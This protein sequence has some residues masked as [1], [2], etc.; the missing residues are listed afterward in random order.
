ME[1]RGSDQ[2]TPEQALGKPGW[3]WAVGGFG[4]VIVEI[5]EG[6]ECHQIDPRT[7]ER[8]GL[9]SDDGWHPEAHLIGPMSREAAMTAAPL[10]PMFDESTA[11]RPLTVN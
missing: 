5:A 4:Y 8:D 6:R 11:N 10:N 9:L 2:Q 1:Q 3:Y 7:G